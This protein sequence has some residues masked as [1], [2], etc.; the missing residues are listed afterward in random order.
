[1]SLLFIGGILCGAA[2]GRCFKV[3]ILVPATFAVAVLV[4]I[5]P[6]LADHSLLQNLLEMVAAVVGLQLGYAVG[7][8]F[9]NVSV[10]FT[11]LRKALIPTAHAPRSR[12]LHVR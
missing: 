5:R 4:L 11:G 3:L 9:G 6:A 7:L 12:S 1:M 2:L 10:G 8:L